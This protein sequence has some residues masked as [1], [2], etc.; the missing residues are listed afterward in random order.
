MWRYLQP[1]PDHHMLSTPSRL[2]Y[3]GAGAWLSGD[4]YMTSSVKALQD[5]SRTGLEDEVR[6]EASKPCS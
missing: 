5:P 4:A 2:K 3:A 6:W 1:S